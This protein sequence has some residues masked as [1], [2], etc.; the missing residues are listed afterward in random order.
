MLP[1]RTSHD[2][3]EPV[4]VRFDAPDGT[5]FGLATDTGELT[6]E[7]LEALAGCDLLA[8]EC[9]HDIDMLMNGPYPWFL[10]KRIASAHGHLSNDA[11][12]TGLE[13]LAHDGLRYVVAR[14]RLEHEQHARTGVR[15][16]SR[17]HPAPSRASR[18]GRM[19]FA[20]MRAYLDTLGGTYSLSVP[21]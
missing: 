3:A 10:K 12:A 8:L 2:A 19:R 16:R 14:A 15:A 7:S 18:R 4:G 17:S 20:S 9:N 11:A 21:R 13:H 6:P 1:F 5:S